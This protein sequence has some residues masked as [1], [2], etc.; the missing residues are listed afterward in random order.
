MLPGLNCVWVN[1]GADAEI[2]GEIAKLIIAGDDQGVAD[3][4]KEHGVSVVAE[5]PGHRTV[6]V[7]DG[8]R[9]HELKRQRGS[10]IHEPVECQDKRVVCFD[11]FRGTV[12]AA[13]YQQTR[14]RRSVWLWP[15]S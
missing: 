8:D 2:S 6:A 14:P 3:A 12:S 7:F 13:L 10:A 4:V 1:P 11:D 15:W 5:M 9:Q